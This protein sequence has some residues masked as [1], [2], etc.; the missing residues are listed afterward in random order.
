MRYD[1]HFLAYPARG[2]GQHFQ[3]T[4]LFATQTHRSQISCEVDP[5]SRAEF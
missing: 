5:R 1:E 2:A 3:G 4:A